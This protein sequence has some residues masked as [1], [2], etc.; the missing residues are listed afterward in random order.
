MTQVCYTKL[1]TRMILCM[2]SWTPSNK[3]RRMIQFGHPVWWCLV[4]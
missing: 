3:L 1:G 2:D 4:R